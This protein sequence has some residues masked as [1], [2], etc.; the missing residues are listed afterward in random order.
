[1]SDQKAPVTTASED[2]ALLETIFDH[3]PV[4]LCHWKG[5]RILRVNR[6]FECRLGWSLEET[7][8]LGVDGLLKAC[9]PTEEARQEVTNFVHHASGEWGEQRTRRKDGRIID[10]AWANLRLADGSTV[11]IGRDISEQKF[12]E[13]QL[14]SQNEQLHAFSARLHSAREEESARIA[15]EIHDEFGCMLTTLRWDLVTCEA[16]AVKLG[17]LQDTGQLQ[18][19][20]EGM[21]K[22]VDGAFTALRRI[23]SEL[24]P[25]VLDHLGLADAIEWQT[26]QFQE[27]SGIT[28]QWE[29]SVE[30]LNL[31]SEQSTAVFRI[32]QEALTNIL[33]HAGATR[34]EVSLAEEDSAVVLKIRD[35]GRGITNQ[36]KQAENSLGLGGMLQRA[37]M[38]GGTVD[39]SGAVNE[40]TVVT[41]RVPLQRVDGQ[42]A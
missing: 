37:R 26:R 35:N 38:A 7:Q 15:R 30:R 34:V 9:A 11:G 20:I 24:R 17:Q 36:E 6:G 16:L 28:C 14:R 33:R 12:V 31:N 25:S 10:T 19:K 41:V 42:S 3:I 40:G 27:R 22:L 13:E 39:I 1:M 5:N 2:K 18:T 29:S 32:S 4:M 21:V 8:A 23:V